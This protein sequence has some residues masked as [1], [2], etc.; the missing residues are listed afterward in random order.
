MAIAMF[1]REGY[2]PSNIID[3]RA[4]FD[5]NEKLLEELVGR[6]LWMVY[7][8][9][10]A[11][12]APYIEGVLFA[13]NDLGIDVVRVLRDLIPVCTGPKFIGDEPVGKKIELYDMKSPAE[14]PK[15]DI[16]MVRS[17]YVVAVEE[18]DDAVAIYIA[19][20]A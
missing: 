14:I 10:T 16:V 3:W 6:Q 20:E 5:G 15:T 7:P 18:R 2:C 11:G 1:E 4:R 12:G 17:G 13:E 9:N 8:K 19:K